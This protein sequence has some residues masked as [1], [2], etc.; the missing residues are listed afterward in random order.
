MGK[1]IREQ[2]W[3][4]VEFNTTSVAL[5]LVNNCLIVIGGLMI[6]SKGICMYV[7]SQVLYKYLHS[8]PEGL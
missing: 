8:V 6:L 1:G 2:F 7:R 5:K 4:D 3:T